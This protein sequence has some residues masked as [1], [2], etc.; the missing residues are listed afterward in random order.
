MRM[1]RPEINLQL[2]CSLYGKTR[3]AY[4][5]HR[6]E[7][8]KTSIAYMIV[9]TLVGEIRKDIPRMGGRKLHHVLVA[10]F[11][12]HGIKIGRD[13]LF[14]LLRFHGLLIRRRKRGVRTTDSYH[15]L[16]KYQNLVEVLKL[17]CPEE[18]WVADITYIK[19]SQGYSYLSLITDAYSRKIVGYAL[20]PTLEATGCVKALQMAIK[21]RTYNTPGLIHHSDRGIQYCCSDYVELLKSEAIAIS[22]TEN[23]NPYDN[24]LAERMNNT[25]KNDY[26]PEKIYHNQK[27]AAVTIDR[28]VHSYNDRRPHQSLD[29]LTPNQAHLMQGSIAKR[30]KNYPRKNKKQTEFVKEMQD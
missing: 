25:I 15:W 4:Y 9:L 19:T 22:M 26:A 6:K 18:L 10:E 14:D 24:A 2:I 11:E 28:I 8:N 29:Y 1:K 30:W 12:K 5:D 7:E 20:H 17:T 16:R 21:Q 3:Q 23:G 13:Q 27:E